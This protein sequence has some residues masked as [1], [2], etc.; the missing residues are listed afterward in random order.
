MYLP[1]MTPS[2]PSITQDFADHGGH[3]E[4]T[5]DMFDLIHEP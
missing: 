2:A 4:R 1:G 5:V 3:N